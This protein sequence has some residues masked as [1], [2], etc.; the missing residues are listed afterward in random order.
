M[1]HLNMAML[2]GSVLFAAVIAGCGSGTAVNK[3]PTTSAISSAEEA[4][5]SASPNA[6]L[7]LLLAKEELQNA[8]SMATKGDKDQAQS[9]LMRAQADGE[10]AIALSHGDADKKEATLA[11]ERVQQLRRDNQLPQE[12]K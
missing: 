4:G 3:E 10:L 7:Y 6:S 8:S 1:R 12:R 11:V 2:A 9:L 5:A